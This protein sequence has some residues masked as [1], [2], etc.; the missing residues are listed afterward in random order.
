MD[1]FSDND[2]ELVGQELI[3]EFD[4]LT[5]K[6]YNIFDDDLNELGD[7]LGLNLGIRSEMVR[8]EV[9]VVVYSSSS[10]GIRPKRRKVRGK[11]EPVAAPAKRS[12]DNTPLI[13][14]SEEKETI[15]RTS[16]SMIR[17]SST[18]SN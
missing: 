12:F 10:F 8:E 18:S 15:R 9:D 2:P 16:S 6:F 1:I 13:L 3:R 14:E 7:Y 17:T 11:V 5:N 4:N